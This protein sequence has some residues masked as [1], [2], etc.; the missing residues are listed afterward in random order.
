[1]FVF[2]FV[3]ME[4][5]KNATCETVS[6]KLETRIT[7]KHVNNMEREKK[8]LHFWKCGYGVQSYLEAPKSSVFFPT[9]RL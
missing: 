9:I 5:E 8:N 6:V 4:D 1:M 3:I 2:G 7:L